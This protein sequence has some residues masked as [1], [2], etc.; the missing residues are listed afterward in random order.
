M[1]I[2]EF[3]KPFEVY[4]DS[5]ITDVSSQI[6]YT[7]NEFNEKADLLCS[8]IRKLPIPLHSVVLI[9]RF[10]STMRS[11]L[12][13]YAS[14]KSGLI[15]FIIETE[16]IGDLDDLKYSA[17]ICDVELSYISVRSTMQ[18]L[19]DGIIYYDC[20][21]ECFIGTD[22]DFIV[23]TSSKST[24]SVSKKILLGKQQTLFNIESNKKALSIVHRD[25]TLILLPLSYCYGLIAQFL[26]HISVGADIIIAPKVLGVMQ[27]QCLLDKYE[28]STLFLTPLLARLLMVYNKRKVRNDLRFATLGGDKPSKSTVLGIQNLLGCPIY[29][30]YGLGEA[31][32]RVA[33]NKFCE[34]NIDADKLSLGIFNEGINASI[35]RSHEY[36]VI[37]NIPGVGYLKIFTQSVYVG[38]IEGNILKKPES[39]LYLITKDIVYERDNEY[40]LLGREDEYLLKNNKL[41]WFQE[42][43]SHFYDNPNILKVIIKKQKNDVLDITIFYKNLC[44]STPEI[45][46]SFLSKYQLQKGIDYSLKIIKYEYNHYK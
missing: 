27:F 44:D 5:V 40:Y 25:K 19:Q 4:K 14:L 3:I 8:E 7:Y 1:K 15:P 29:G 26:T 42:I 20:N 46:S 43:K 13:F 16:D 9:Y 2:E 18:P 39:Q 22:S 31:G 11:L 34:G 45:E 41:Y 37:T 24:S 28:I 33:T 35:I 23:A 38:Y 30:T 32:P 36:E 6:V 21:R 10:S 17:V 12:Y